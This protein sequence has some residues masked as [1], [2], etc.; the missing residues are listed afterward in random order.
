MGFAVATDR[1]LASDIRAQ[2]TVAQPISD[3][4]NPPTRAGRGAG[5]PGRRWT[6]WITTSEDIVLG[7]NSGDGLLWRSQDAGRTWQTLGA[8]PFDVTLDPC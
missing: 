8:G 2:Q 1:W 6:L 3:Y 5:Q 4:W 7:V